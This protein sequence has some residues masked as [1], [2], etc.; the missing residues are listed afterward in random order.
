M[1]L[2][3][4][5]V[6]L[7]ARDNLSPALRQ[8]GGEAQKLGRDLEQAGERG[9]RSFD[10]LKGSAGAFGAAAGTVVSG[11][12][13]AGQA[14]YE[15]ER[16]TEALSR[17]Y[18][19][20]AEEMRRF[21][22]EIQRTTN[23]S[24][25]QAR[26]AELTAATLARAYGLTADQIQT[27]IQ[28][29]ADLAQTYGI[30]L[31]DATSRVAG[32]IRGEGEAAEM[33]G[34]NLSDAAV[35][36]AA[37]AAGL[38]GWNT[39]MTESEKAAF[40]YNLLLSQTT[41]LQGTAADAADGARGR[42]ID[43]Q[44]AFQDGIVSIGQWSGELGAALS[45]LGDMALVLPAVT[46][47]IGKMGGLGTLGRFAGPAAL[48]AGGASLA[49][50][51]SQGDIGVTD[52]N[53][54]WNEF[55]MTGAGIFN[56]LTPGSVMDVD[57]YRKQIEQNQ[58]GSLIN[59]V[60]LGP[61][62]DQSVV[63]DRISQL[64][65]VITGEMS[66]DQLIQFVVDKAHAA[67][68]TVDA[69]LRGLVQT[70]PVYITDPTTGTAMPRGD[71]TRYQANR[72]GAMGAGLSSGYTAP[73]LPPG[74]P[75]RD[76]YDAY[77][78]ANGG[79]ANAMFGGTSYKNEVEGWQNIERY[80]QGG[81]GAVANSGLIPAADA[82]AATAAVNDYIAAIGGI[83][84]NTYDADMALRAL[85]ATQDGLLESQQVYSAQQ[86]EYSSQQ[87]A[88]T[89]AYEV[90]QERQ[91]QGVALTAEEQALLTNYPELY[92]R[93]T[94]GVDDATVAQG[95]L[96]AQYI[97]NMERGDQMNASLNGNTSAVDAL[98][99]TV[100]TL[101]MLLGGIPPEVQTQI[102]INNANEALG[103]LQA[104][105]N[106]INAIDGRVAN[107]YVNVY[108]TGIS[109]GNPDGPG[110]EQLQHG[111]V[112][113]AQHGR[114]LGRGYTLVG[115]AGPELLL[116]GQGAMVVPASATRA[117]RGDGAPMYKDCTFTIVANDPEDFDRQ[118]RS[119]AVGW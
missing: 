50:G 29:S 62:E 30:T 66:T 69:Y 59:N 26:N 63:W 83:A 12:S 19:A 6:E 56:M 84:A 118:M 18:G 79:Y 101:I 36:A 82:A 75:E 2:E 13:L 47:M 102:T 86:S 115:E 60:L 114:L 45:V 104:A 91:A 42:M 16:Q 53:Q 77:L 116:G 21:A 32:A 37:A 67:N 5:S 89:A 98:N 76:A 103:Q 43:L 110:I 85:K 95:L 38:T 113:G 72:P 74:N 31:T 58:A 34:L 71:F 94:G 35:A 73:N 100:E 54:F 44:H 96:A 22:D 99:A 88:L 112:V 14:A 93:I 111:G 108:R 61:G 109:I 106:A 64:T 52:T 15:T 28:R 97:E 55:F 11:L 7:R 27:L 119:R 70:N 68:Q 48:V 92:A 81:S 105:V 65:G 40:R 17:Q 4:H 90:L 8:A 10:R 57:K 41:Q 9:S 33:L 117:R 80:Q 87:S 39:T 51:Y 78:A 20:S 107:A 3:V 46:G 24:N 49:Y 1:A 23:F 25:D